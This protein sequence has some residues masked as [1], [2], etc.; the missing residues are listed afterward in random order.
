MIKS[1]TA[2]ANAGN[3]A[4]LTT[5][6]IVIALVLLLGATIYL[7]R[8]RYIRRRSAYVLMAFCV[9]ALAALAFWMLGNPLA[10]G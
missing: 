6:A 5:P 4:S 9:I 10:G 3:S 1:P 8:A 7:W 2:A